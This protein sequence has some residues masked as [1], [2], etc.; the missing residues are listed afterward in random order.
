MYNVRLNK[1]SRCLLIS[2]DYHTDTIYHYSFTSTA[3]A[4]RALHIIIRYTCKCLCEIRKPKVLLLNIR[5]A[6]FTHHYQLTQYHPEA[7]AA[8]SSGSIKIDRRPR[9]CHVR[10]HNI[11]II[12]LKTYYYLRVPP[13]PVNTRCSIINNDVFRSVNIGT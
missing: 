8:S 12:L 13:P 3:A 6:G 1:V 4:K 9:R 10:Q 11:I 2:N 5:S 7:W